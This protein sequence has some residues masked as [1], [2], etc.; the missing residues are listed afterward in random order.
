[1]LTRVD[2]ERHVDGDGLQL[3]R[4]TDLHNI[5]FLHSRVLPNIFTN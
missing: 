2:S 3:I 5:P 4:L 1:M